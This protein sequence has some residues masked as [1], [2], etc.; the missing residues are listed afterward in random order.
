MA[1]EAARAP[2][3]ARA[4]RARIDPALA[5]LDAARAALLLDLAEYSAVAGVRVVVAFD[6]MGNPEAPGLQRDTVAGVDVVFCA[7]SDA[8]AFLMSEARRLAD[9]GCPRVVVA[10]SDREIQL[11]LDWAAAGW[12]PSHTLLREMAR[13]LKAADAA[14]ATQAAVDRAAAGGLGASLKGSQ[15]AG[16]AALKERLLR[17]RRGGG[18]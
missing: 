14:Y 7:S 8:D 13:A 16:L 9:A 18:R 1:Y 17:E 6:A 15:A 5:P 12:V 11:S 10:S 4:R 3:L 2:G